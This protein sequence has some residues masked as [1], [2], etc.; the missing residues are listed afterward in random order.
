MICG[1][2]FQPSPPLLQILGF[3]FI[4]SVVDIWPDD[5]GRFVLRLANEHVSDI[6]TKIEMLDWGAFQGSISRAL[7]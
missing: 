6:L 1:V 3:A 4:L 7:C 2:R 5:L